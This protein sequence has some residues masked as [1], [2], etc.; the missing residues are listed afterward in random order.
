MEG[1]GSSAA[2]VWEVGCRERFPN[3][4]KGGAALL[5]F[6][7]LCAL[8]P[9]QLDLHVGVERKRRGVPTFAME[10]DE[11]SRGPVA[12]ES[13]R[14]ENLE[15]R[16]PRLARGLPDG[17]RRLD[18]A[19]AVPSPSQG[20]RSCNGTKFSFQPEGGASCPKSGG[21]SRQHALTAP[22]PLQGRRCM[23]LPPERKAL[24]KKE[25]TPAGF[26]EKHSDSRSLKTQ[27]RI[28]RRRGGGA[29]GF[30]P[31]SAVYVQ[32]L[33]ILDSLV[34]LPDGASSQPQVQSSQKSVRG[35][36]ATAEG[37]NGPCF[38]L[39]ASGSS[40]REGVVQPSKAWSE[41]GDGPPAQ[42]FRGA[43]GE[44]TLQLPALLRGSSESLSLASDAETA[45]E[46][47]FLCSEGGEESLK[48]S[49]TQGLVSLLA[50]LTT[51]APQRV[52][53]LSKPPQVSS[54][55]MQHLHKGPPSPF[56]SRQTDPGTFARLLGVS[57]KGTR[58]PA[59]QPCL[60]AEGTPLAFA[61]MHECAA[62][63]EDE[64]FPEEEKGVPDLA[65]R[66][67][68]FGEFVKVASARRRRSDFLSLTEGVVKVFV[69]L[70]FSV[71]A[72]CRFRGALPRASRS[73][74]CLWPSA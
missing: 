44:K 59:D 8:G 10:Q 17:R 50:V 25:L 65:R 62:F 56:T 29:R 61:C 26:G 69:L 23:S 54:D 47:P 30:S 45:G 34:C 66:L 20:E 55:G 43:G 36:S 4:V 2:S 19:G 6:K 67:M 57:V 72:A 60:L 41:N 40:W 1:K 38:R 27:H 13:L 15:A 70:R 12:G 53:I 32:P 42:S 3:Y 5:Y 24:K 48:T 9:L 74:A 63:E 31:F 22:Q 68:E 35:L 14:L 64:A 39:A 11:A 18:V 37:L 71:N 7:A 73:F 49:H 28:H 46:R 52:Y 51:P 16:F 33:R 21:L 58:R